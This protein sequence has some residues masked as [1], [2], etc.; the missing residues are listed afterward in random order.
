M[1]PSRS[2]QTDCTVDSTTTKYY[3]YSGGGSSG[4]S[5]V[6]RVSSTYPAPLPECIAYT[7]HTATKN[8][9]TTKYYYC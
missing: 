6:V 7:L 2:K 4:I 8:S 3:Y 5:V 1:I 9:I